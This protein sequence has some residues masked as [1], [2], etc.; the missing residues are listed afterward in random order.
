MDPTDMVDL[1]ALR[2]QTL[3][4]A[5]QAELILA[6]APAERVGTAAGTTGVPSAASMAAQASNEVSTRT[7]L[8]ASVASA[9][10]S[11]RAP[12]R[13]SRAS[14][15]LPTRR[16]SQPQ[17]L[18]GHGVCS[19]QNEAAEDLLLDREELEML[20]V[21]HRSFNLPGLRL[22]LVNPVCHDDFFPP[23]EDQSPAAASSTARS[24]FVTSNS[25][26][27][28]A[29]VAEELE[30]DESTCSSGEAQQLR[31]LAP[32]QRLPTPV[33]RERNEH[34]RGRKY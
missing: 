14:E 16:F 5:A 10:V 34:A 29:E 19:H 12:P 22:G 27:G 9:E 30:E 7:L 21:F 18:Q 31:S 33:L 4:L 26:G 15:E 23:D 8:R 17:P 2:Q 11:S 28:A 13:P 1:L 24:C 6:G 32:H 20:R 3:G 25:P